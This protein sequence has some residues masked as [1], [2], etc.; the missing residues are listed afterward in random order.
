MAKLVAMIDFYSPLWESQ[1]MDAVFKNGTDEEKKDYLLAHG[2]LEE[3]E[4]VD[5]DEIFD[6]EIGRGKDFVIYYD[7][8]GML[9]SVKLIEL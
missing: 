7:D 2:K 5:E 3:P 4:E 6:E 9:E 8:W 1:E